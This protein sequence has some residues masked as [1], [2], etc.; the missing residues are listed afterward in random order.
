VTPTLNRPG[1]VRNVLQ[2]IAAQ[3]YP[4]VESVVV[5]DGGVRL[6]EIVAAFPF[7]RVLNLPQNVG[8]LRAELEGIAIARGEFIQL[9]ADDDWLYPD[10]IERLAFALLRTGGSIAHGNILIRYQER[11]ADETL[12]TTGFNASVFAAT[13]TPSDALICTPIAGQALLI[14][15]TV[16][17]EIGSWRPDC[18]LADQ[19]FQTRAAARYPFVWVDHVTG[20]HRIRG[21]S[22]FNKSGEESAR[23][24]QRIF[25]EMHPIAGRPMLQAIRD[26]TV[27]N[28]AARKPGV[29]VFAPSII[30]R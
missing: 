16:L 10:H 14:R 11:Q 7:A 15:R 17:D 18:F 6:D 1:D 13:T 2:C 8:A 28:V 26:A 12:V 24:M 25:E 4:K 29:Q 23:E 22:L 3:R 5:N 21:E 19:E 30:L 27:A 20:E 9:L